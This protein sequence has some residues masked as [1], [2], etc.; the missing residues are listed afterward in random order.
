MYRFSASDVFWAL[1]MIAWLALGGIAMVHAVAGYHWH[2]RAIAEFNA[3]T[4][5][6][7]AKSP[8]DPAG[9]DRLIAEAVGC[10]LTIGVAL[11]AIRRRRRGIVESR[12][13]WIAA[14]QARNI[15]TQ[16]AQL[17]AT[18][19]APSVRAPAGPARAANSGSLAADRLSVVIW[20]DHVA[21]LKKEHA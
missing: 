1:F 18:T 2:Q 17:Q 16:A 15:P 12:V 5:Q 8:Y 9:D 19:S 6:I 3:R 20:S 21:R 13:K 4:P 14:P 11:I 7:V 10:V